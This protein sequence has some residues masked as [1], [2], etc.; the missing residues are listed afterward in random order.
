[1]AMRPTDTL[2]ADGAGHALWRAVE[3]LD[4]Q[5]R[6]R[7]LHRRPRKWLREELRVRHVDFD[8]ETLT[9]GVDMQTLGRRQRGGVE[10]APRWLAGLLDVLIEDAG[11]VV[12]RFDDERVAVEMSD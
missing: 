7:I 8:N 6:R 12:G 2:L 9:R 1:M 4:L 11:G 5:I 10:Q 3:R